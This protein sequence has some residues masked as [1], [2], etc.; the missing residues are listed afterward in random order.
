MINNNE[1][2]HFFEEVA[3]LKKR[4][5]L[6]RRVLTDIIEEAAENREEGS[7]REERQQALKDNIIKYAYDVSTYGCA[8]GC[9][10]SLIYYTDTTQ[11]FLSYRLFI[12]E[13][14][15]DMLEETGFT[16]MS[17][18]FGDKWDDSDPLAEET[19]NQNLLAWFAYEQICMEIVNIN[20]NL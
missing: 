1:V 8:S 16:G 14:L 5:P 2:K 7:T 6:Y 18:L 19:T 20:E 15:A 9:V 3:D 10:G 12:N 11:F 4:N 13:M 17:E